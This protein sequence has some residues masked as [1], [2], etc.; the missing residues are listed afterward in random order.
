MGCTAKQWSKNAIY[1]MIF[2]ETIEKHINNPPKIQENNYAISKK[3][4]DSQKYPKDTRKQK[5]V[6][7]APW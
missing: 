5:E 2:R 3:K 1:S 6:N 7:G 4:K